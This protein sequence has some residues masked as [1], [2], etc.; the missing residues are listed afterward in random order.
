ML[1]KGQSLYSKQLEIR[2]LGFI[3]SKFRKSCA[4]AWSPAENDTW[5]LANLRPRPVDLH[6]MRLIRW[7]QGKYP[8]GRFSLMDSVLFFIDKR[9]LSHF[10]L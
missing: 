6:S 2:M 1:R 4:P 3:T 5:H 8:D 9:F 10:Y 7:F